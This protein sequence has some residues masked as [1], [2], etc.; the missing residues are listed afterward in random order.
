MKTPNQNNSTDIQTELLGLLDEK[1]NEIHYNKFSVMFP[2]T[3]PY[4]REFYQKHVAF[5]A[6]GVDFMERAFIAANRT[7]KTTAGAYEMACHLT[8]IY[9]EWWKGRKFINAIEAWAASVTSQT[10][11][12]GVQK[13]LLGPIVDIGSGMVPKHLIALK[14]DG[15]Y[16]LSR[17]S[18]TPDAVETL[19]VTHVSGELSS[20]TFKSYDQGPEVFQ[21]VK[22]QVIWLDEEPKESKI[23]SECLTRLMDKFNPGI[24]YCTFTPLFGISSQIVSSFLPEGVF[25]K[26]GVS[27]N[28]PDKY[29]ANVTWNDVPHMDDKQKAALLRSYAPQEREARSKG[30]PSMGAGAVYPYLEDDILVEPF[31]IPAWWPRGY[32]LDVGW[33]RTAALW[34]ALDP[35]TGT[36]YFYSEHYMGHE[37]IPVHSSAIKSRGEWIIGAAD[38][39][40]TNPADGT[41]M[42]EL[43]LLEGLNL[44]KADKR[45]VEAGIAKI[46]T[47]F[48]AKQIKIFNTLQNWLREKR[49]YR[50]DEDNKIVKKHDHLM[51]AMRY[52][53]F[54][55]L[56][57]LELPPDFDDGSPAKLMKRYNT[58]SVTGY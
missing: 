2:N 15:S 11:R 5:M 55:G 40:G 28:N 56:D 21:V 43:Y 4:A 16:M 3:G 53:I 52:F 27:A 13:E 47:M 26:N 7:G 8:G 18:G 19:Y 54:T 9:P 42:F 34:G 6:A 44:V 10:T 45:S 58:N 35:D 25:P 12:D 30:I 57:W 50:R 29:I 48:E 33:N 24:L 39:D 14:S 31:A 37:R 23:Y 20:I 38:P 41:K 17:K 51:D 32:G 46:C 49:G 36:I 1:Y 22:R